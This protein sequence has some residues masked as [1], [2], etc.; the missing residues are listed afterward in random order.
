VGV[1]TNRTPNR[2]EYGFFPKDQILI[3]EGPQTKKG[4]RNDN[5]PRQ[6]RK[7]PLRTEYVDQHVIEQQVFQ[8]V[9]IKIVQAVFQIKG[10]KESHPRPQGKQNQRKGKGGTKGKGICLVIMPNTARETESIETD[11]LNARGMGKGIKKDE[12]PQQTQKA[13]LFRVEKSPCVFIFKG[14]RAPYPSISVHRS[15]QDRRSASISLSFTYRTNM[16]YASETA[17][18]RPGRPSMHPFFTT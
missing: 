17:M 13:P 14:F 12:N 6:P 18:I 1:C 9:G 15:F 3:A 5:D 7:P 11:F 16:A 8:Q 10:E 4:C 2:V